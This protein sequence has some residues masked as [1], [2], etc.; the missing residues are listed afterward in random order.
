LHI[1]ILG[2]AFGLGKAVVD[3]TA[4]RIAVIV[5]DWARD[6]FRGRKRDSKRPVYF[7]IR[8]LDGRLVMSVLVKNATDEPEDHTVEDQRRASAAKKPGDEA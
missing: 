1:S 6:R 3:E 8:D 2:A 7:A 5:V 4:K